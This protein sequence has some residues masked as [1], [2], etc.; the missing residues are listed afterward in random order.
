M[1]VVIDGKTIEAIPGETI[2]EC[3]L[4]N[5]ISIP[6]LCTHPALPP[7]GAC[8]ICIVEVEGMRGYPTS[9]STPVTE[10]MI[11]RTQSD[12][13]KALRRNILGL[14]MLEHPSACLVCERREL[15]DRYRP[16]S[17]KVG[18]TTGC[19]TCNNKEV[20]EVRSLSA[21]LNLA[22]IMV[23]PQYH[24]KP[25]ERSEPFIDRDLNLC[26]L[27]GR[28]V[29]ICKLHQ[30]HAVIDFIH[31]GSQTH[32]GQAFGRNL[33]EAGC[34]FCGSCVDVCPTGTLSDRYAKWFGRPDTMIETT[35]IYCDE[36]CALAV[37]S[38]NQKAVTVKG[39][40][41]HIPIC[42]LGRF[43]IP[44][45]LNSP[46]RLRTPQIRVNK[47]LRP[48]THEETIQRCDELLRNYT[49]NSFAFVCDTCSTLEDRFVFKKFTREIMKSPYYFEIIPDKKGYA[50]L[51]NI[52]SEVKAIITTGPFIPQ[53]LRNQFEVVIALDIFPSDWTK[54]ADVIYPVG[55]FAEVSG[56]VLDKSNYPRPLVKAC[57]P[58]GEARPEWEVIQS[59]A[60]ILSPELWEHFEHVGNIT[61]TL[62]LEHAGLNSQ[63]KEPPSPSQKLS[64]RREWFKGHRIENHVSGLVSVRAFEEGK[65]IEIKKPE[66]VPEEVDNREKPFVVLSRR[67]L[68]PNTYEFVIYAPTI[69][70]KALPGQFVI[71]MVDENS[72]R[73]PYTLSDWNEEKG[74]ITLV[75]QEKGLSSR[76][77]ISVPQGKALAHVVGP[78]GTAF[79]VKQ[80]GTVVLLGGCYGIGAIVRLSRALKEQGNEV[81]T[82][83][84]ARSHY[85]AYYQN[86]L[87]Q[88]SNQFIQTTIDG[89]LG[90]KGHAIDA[91]KRMLANGKHID[92]VVAVGCPFMMM[93]TAEE[94]R[95]TDVKVLCALNPIMLDGTGM[96]GA[97]RISVNGQT[98]FACVDGPF[99]DAHQVDWDEVRDRREAYSNEEIQAVSY[100]MP[101]ETVYGEQRHHHCSCME[102]G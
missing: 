17:E 55:V 54:S 70:R 47:V 26:I 63:R 91:L 21:D 14:M 71:V 102:R 44:E 5:G 72:E 6:H 83:A 33:H 13:L 73:I 75:V 11:I 60:E 87:I 52:P 84:E 69:A 74:T 67:E 80:Y 79:E 95:T 78:L 66:S 27:C 58:P 100:T 22:E 49:G 51:Q 76:K 40:Y 97:C 89:S 96:C 7:F 53:E 45:F 57:N 85:L 90:E 32:I 46:E 56:T 37:Y 43:A 77:M 62:E 20:C 16:R 9:C 38:V 23:A 86:E 50:T 41:D 59:I 28:C 15:C 93:V 82:I 36:A 10:G 18:A 68:V 81:I 19:H 34:T 99:F 8:R 2:L 92:L 35:C 1:N 42:V 65:D 3:A 61:H 30:G 88:V 25:I 24:Y 64:E 29:R 94:T 4:R 31:R 48:V 12:T 98:R 39:L 101:T